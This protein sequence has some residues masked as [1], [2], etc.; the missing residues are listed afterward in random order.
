MFTGIVESVGEIVAVEQSGSDCRMSVRGG[1]MDLV[2]LKLGDSVCVSGVCLTVTVLDNACFWVDVSAE[3]LACTT[4]GE[5]SVGGHV[6]LEQAVTP[7][8]RLGGHLVSGHVDGVGSITSLRED[9]RSTR[10]RVRVPVEITKYIAV[11]GS[12]CV[13]GISLTVNGVVGDEFHVNIIPH[14]MKKTTM[15][16]FKEGRRVNIE[17]DVVARYLERLLTADHDSGK[18]KRTITADFLAAHGY[19][20]DDS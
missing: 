1:E 20:R 18:K 14:T 13:D 10:V 2:G 16:E 19:A 9:G 8:T 7:S 5:L 15:H 11:K 17:V 12:V 3:T 6:N 4:L